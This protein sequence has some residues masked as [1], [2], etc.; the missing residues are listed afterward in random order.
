MKLT[1]FERRSA[2]LYVVCFV[3]ES[4]FEAVS[5]RLR[6][7]EGSMSLRY[8]LLG[9]REQ[10]AVEDAVIAFLENE[11]FPSLPSDFLGSSVV[12]TFLPDGSGVRFSAGFRT[13]VVR[14]EVAD[15]KVDLSARFIDGST[16]ETVERT[17]RRPENFRRKRNR[18]R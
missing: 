2:V 1:R 7:D 10:L 12:R 17:T 13:L 18:R 5:P 4:G 14:F 15:R 3:A 8:R 6:P 11:V 9:A 16:G